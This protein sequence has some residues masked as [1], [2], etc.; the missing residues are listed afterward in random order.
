MPRAWTIAA[1]ALAAC[2]PGMNEMSTTLPICTTVA[3][4]DSHDGERVVLVGV[5]RFFPD[6]PGFDYT[7]VPRAVQITLDDD[8][9]P[10]L[11]PYWSKQALRPE[12]EVNA[13]LGKR[14]RVTG[15]YRRIQPPNPKNPPE[16][17]AMGGP[18]IEVEKIEP[19]E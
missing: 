5:Y 7:G 19:A 6:K 2:A 4:C 10:W 11:E 15:R 9:G 13:Y 12:A 14:V 17:S 3:A 18:C 16:A 8:N 1:L